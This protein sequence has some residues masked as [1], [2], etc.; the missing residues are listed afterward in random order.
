MRCS[1]S[2]L[3]VSL[4]AAVAAGMLAVAPAIAQRDGTF[5]SPPVLVPKTPEPKPEVA[6]KSA[7][8][9]R[10]ETKKA[11]AKAPRLEEEKKVK[12]APG[13][14]KPPKKQDEKRE[15]ELAHEG[16]LLHYFEIAEGACAWVVRNIGTERE[17]VWH[18]TETCPELVLWDPKAR[19]SIYNQKGEL[20]EVSWPPLL[21]LADRPEPV[22]PGEEMEKETGAEPPAPE[23]AEKASE[24]KNQPETQTK[25]K[26]GSDA[27]GEATPEGEL[28][29][30]MP[31]PVARGP[32]PREYAKHPERAGLWIDHR[33]GRLRTAVIRAPD[34]A[35]VE[36][37]VTRTEKVT[38]E[39]DGKSVEVE[40]EVEETAWSLPYKGKMYDSP[41]REG[42]HG[43]ATIVAVLEQRDGKWVTVE[44]AGAWYAAGDG[45]PGQF[46]P[47][48]AKRRGTVLGLGNYL[49][50]SSWL[51]GLYALRR[52]RLEP[53]EKAVFRDAFAKRTPE[54]PEAS[55]DLALVPVRHGALALPVAGGAVEGA[56][57]A[58][59]PVYYARR[60]GSRI[61]AALNLPAFP[62]PEPKAVP[63]TPKAEPEKTATP[64][65]KVKTPKVLKR[66]EETGGVQVAIQEGAKKPRETT[67]PE[68]VKKSGLEAR[69]RSPHGL[70][71]GRAGSYVLVAARETGD[72]PAVYRY[73]EPDPVFTR[74]KG[75]AAI[76]IYFSDF[77]RTVPPREPSDIRRARKKKSAKKKPGDVPVDGRRPVMTCDGKGCR[78]VRG[79]PAN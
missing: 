72:G 10:T 30:K 62:Q 50:S 63:E 35:P 69:P 23:A 67:K 40:K 71:I 19:R 26:N 7:P 8:G 44:R 21:L 51:A 14:I 9:N 74:P 36:R 15:E 57:Q 20:F 75:R 48:F 37:K 49:R 6:P 61:G 58:I 31:E 52:D 13:S 68:A 53:E 41:P 17:L 60:D 43:E 1:L 25:T 3:R 4:M 66:S 76:W 79:N 28:T 39:K 18:T 54:M 46:A 64:E 42:E 56:L 38:E 47:S 24:K 27:E 77:W 5:A 33:S 55:V 29:Y 34:G 70:N 32:L 45:P 11:P 22:D 78:P 12:L 16:P 73:G 2:I 59:P 65:R